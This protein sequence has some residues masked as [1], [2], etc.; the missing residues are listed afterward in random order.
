MK[1]SYLTNL[2]LIIILGLLYWLNTQEPD[3]Q[4]APPALSKISAKS[5]NQIIISQSKRD[6]IIL[7]KH[8]EQWQL[9][10]PI[11]V[12]ANPTRINLLLSLL[13]MHSRRQQPVLDPKNLEQFGFDDNSTRL[14]L[15]EQLFAFGNLEP[16]SQQRYMLH[17]NVIYLIDDT[18]SPLLN[19]RAN[20][21]IDSR[22]LPNST[23][24][25]LSLPMYKNQSIIDDTVSLTFAGSH[26]TSSPKQ[27]ADTLT[28]LVD[29][30]RRAYA[31]QVIPL[32]AI[33]TKL[34]KQTGQTALIWFEQHTTPLQLTLYLTD[35]ALFIVNP[36]LNLAYQFP[37]KLYQ[38]LLLTIVT[39]DA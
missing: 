21:F 4:Q 39:N 37:P 8:A 28:S 27:S 30:W 12:A 34:E 6:D 29:T 9:T 32:D 11:Q 36:K 19:T 3:H 13:N 17:N 33:A 5:I 2:V 24:S 1:S 7:A 16:I 38:Q 20:S 22:L 15:G 31:L 14:Q 26:W 35:N 23:I 18:I 25:K 10:Q